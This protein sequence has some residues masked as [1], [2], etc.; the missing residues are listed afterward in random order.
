MLQPEF[1]SVQKV[2]TNTLFPFSI[3]FSEFETRENKTLHFY[4]FSPQSPKFEVMKLHVST[5][6]QQHTKHK[7]SQFLSLFSPLVRFRN[8]ETNNFSFFEQLLNFRFFSEF[9]NSGIP[10]Y[11]IPILPGENSKLQPLRIPFY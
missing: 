11:W 10:F 8:F 1:P 6:V 5:A 2:K 9:G 7:N 4:Y 3:D